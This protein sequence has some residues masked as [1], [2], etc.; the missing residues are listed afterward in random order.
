MPMSARPVGPG[1]SPLAERLALVP[2]H[3]S[4][5]MAHLAVQFGTHLPF[6]AA[7]RLLS[8]ACGTRVP[9]DT[10]RRLTERAGA[11]WWQ[12]E[13]EMVHAV[14]TAALDP[15]AAPVAVPD[16]QVVTP[17]RPVQLSIDGAMVPLVRGEWAEVRT[18]VIGEV[19]TTRSGPKATALSY[20]SALASATDFSRSVL[21]ELTRRGVL[22]HAGPIVAITDGAV[23]I[24]DVLDLQ[25]PHAV[26]ILDIMHAIAYLADAAKA[27]FGPGTAE[28]SEWLADQRH[29]LRQGHAGQVLAALATLPPDATRE[30]AIRYLS[31]RRSMLDYARC[32]ATGW[33]VGSGAVE[34][35]N[36]V[37]VEARLK[38]AGMH[39]SRC[40]V[41]PMVALR[42]LDASDRWATAWP[43]IV[44]AWRA[45]HRHRMS[46]RRA[47]RSVPAPLATPAVDPPPPPRA[48]APTPRPQL[49][50]DGKPTADHPWRQSGRPR[51]ATAQGSH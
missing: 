17:E 36:K 11:V 21:G 32:D 33:P 43:R 38:G 42:A 45:D 5:A 16:Q 25:C 30:T 7:A 10:V 18:L 41:T 19:A 4:P 9:H 26:R 40:H 23:W 6:A 51:I 20:V 49:V 44:T 15:R 47:A 1:F 14:E 50:V 35:A 22:R 8:A 39:W 3:L 34:S 48:P 27:A 29:A 2:G 28:T 31:G 13:L 12:L 37:I 24:Q 46:R